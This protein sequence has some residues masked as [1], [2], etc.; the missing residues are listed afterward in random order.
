MEI[1]NS[2]LP[3]VP[4]DT[5]LFRTY[6][7]LY[8][9]NVNVISGFDT[10]WSPTIAVLEVT[11]MPYNVSHFRRIAQDSRRHPRLHDTTVGWQDGL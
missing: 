2:M 6:G 10:A 3:F 8:A 4:R 1:Y 9:S 5:A 11:R 7:G